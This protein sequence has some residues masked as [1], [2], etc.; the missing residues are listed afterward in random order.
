MTLG[1]D[2]ADEVIEELEYE[3]FLDAANREDFSDVAD[4]EDFDPDDEY[5]NEMQASGEFPAFT[6]FDDPDDFYSGE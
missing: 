4:Q 5:Y 1:D 3:D 6:D 2:Y